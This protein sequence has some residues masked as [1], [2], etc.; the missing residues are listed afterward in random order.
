MRKLILA[1]IL[2]CFVVPVRATQAY[3]ACSGTC[4]NTTSTASLTLPATGTLTFTTG[5]FLAI[6][7]RTANT[8]T[9]NTPTDTLSN[10]FHCRTRVDVNGSSASVSLCYAYNITGGSDTITIT[11]SGAI[12]LQAFVAEY[13]GSAT[14]CDPVSDIAQVSGTVVGGSTVT[15]TS[16]T[17]TGTES[18]I[19]STGTGTNQTSWPAS[20]SSFTTRSPNGGS[21]GSLPRAALSDRLNLAASSYTGTMAI[22]TTSDAVAIMSAVHQVCPAAGTPNMPP[23]VLTHLPSFHWLLYWMAR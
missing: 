8:V 19:L 10:T 7:I 20:G 11:T 18:L 12:N 21:S 5:N 2:I 16:M 3:V 17:T 13:S 23:V 22:N 1:L 4:S 9:L 15:T 14:A 6:T